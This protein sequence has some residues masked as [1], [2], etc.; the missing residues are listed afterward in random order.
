MNVPYWNCFL[1][2]TKDL[3]GP[4][5]WIYNLVGIYLP[6]EIKDGFI[7]KSEA[8]TCGLGQKLSSFLD[9]SFLLQPFR[10]VIISCM[11]FLTSHFFFSV[12]YFIFLLE[13]L[14]F[15]STEV[16]EIWDK[17]KNWMI[18]LLLITNTKTITKKMLI[19]KNAF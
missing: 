3:L 1:R 10:W 12:I 5:N 18:K 8:C 13:N 14:N 11:Q 7:L 9:T 19:L 6:I 16:C 15:E 4:K 17:K 2:K